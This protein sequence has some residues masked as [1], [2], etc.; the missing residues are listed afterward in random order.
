MLSNGSSNP[1]EVAPTAGTSRAAATEELADNP[2]EIDEETTGE[3]G[4]APLPQPPQLLK[5]PRFVAP[6]EL[7]LPSRAPEPAKSVLST[8]AERP[9]ITPA[10]AGSSQPVSLNQAI[11]PPVIPEPASLVAA[12]ILGPSHT[13]VTPNKTVSPVVRESP[14]SITPV[15]ESSRAVPPNNTTNSATAHK[16][17]HLVT[18]PVLE[19]SPAVTSDRVA[20]SPIVYKPPVLTDPSGVLES[21]QATPHRQVVVSQK[22]VSPSQATHPP[23]VIHKSRPIVVHRS[24]DLAGGIAGSNSGAAMI[25]KGVYRLRGE[26][27]ATKANRVR[28]DSIEEAPDVVLSLGKSGYE[29]ANPPSHSENDTDVSTPLPAPP[30]STTPSSTPSPDE[31][32]VPSSQQ[33]LEEDLTIP[34]EVETDSSYP[35]ALM[36]PLSQQ[37]PLTTTTT[38]S[39][40]SR[41]APRMIPTYNIDRSDIPSWL[42]E[43]GRLD[44]VLSVKAGDLW[45][46]LI[47]TWIRQE[48]RLAFGLNEKLVSRSTL[49]LHHISNVKSQGGCLSL[50]EK[51]NVLKDY[52]K[53]HHSPSK[54]DSVRPLELGDEV[55]D[56]WAGLQPKWRY[57]E[58]EFPD[59]PKDY[60]FILAGGKKGIFLLILCLAWWDNA[61]G[62]ELEG[63]MAERRE[64]AKAA[65]AT[66]DFGGLR[67]HEPKWFNIVNDLIFVMELAQGWPAPGE[68]TLGSVGVTTAPKKRV[69]KRGNSSS[70]RKKKKTS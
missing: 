10:V 1:G 14:S 39:G 30:P 28:R 35:D 48:R 36:T 61:H 40:Q 25:T 38:L 69:A 70:P 42:L 64:A 19:S 13:A 3:F 46:K 29:L 32:I 56:W 6:R 41:F 51:P 5:T 52:F 58:E 15:L 45:K 2:P 53:W 23:N 33:S 63:D 54:G 9:L 60:S 68:S 31:F 44:Y 18:S 26:V 65:G 22:S 7:L 20:I 11:V 16:S 4:I 62:R 37:G 24:P 34:M 55:W 47:T 67:E 57:K 43:R 27:S 49:E 8:V 21:S 66:V 50:R 12:P 59:V 17:P